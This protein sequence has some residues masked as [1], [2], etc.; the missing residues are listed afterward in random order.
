M[1]TVSRA[2]AYEHS[3][4]RGKVVVKVLVEAVTRRI[5][6]T[7]GGNDDEGVVA[8]ASIEYV[9]QEN[10]FLGTLTMQ[11]T[12]TY[13]THLWLPTIGKREAEV[14]VVVEVV[15]LEKALQECADRLIRN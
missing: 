15:I 9:R 10:M 6:R 12:I 8:I 5:L 13:S 4:G 2:G 11:E 7:S 3:S 14:A 1:P